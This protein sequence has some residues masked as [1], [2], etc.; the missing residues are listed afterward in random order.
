MRHLPFMSRSV[1]ASMLARTTRLVHPSGITFETPLL[2][3]SFSSKGF[4]HSREDGSS[5]LADI[6]RVA[7]EF[8]TDSMLVSAYDMNHELFPAINSP[9]THITIVDSGGYEVSDQHDL[10]SV[11]VQ[12]VEP[13]EWNKERHRKE[14]ERWPGHV[15][16]IFVTY[17][18]GVTRLPIRQQLEGAEDYLSFSDEHLITFLLRPET[19][20]QKYVQLDS[21]KKEVEGLGHFAMLGLTEKELGKS[22][23]ERM[24]MI[25]RIR[26]VLDEASARVP[27]HIFGCLDPISIPLYFMAGAEVFDGLAWLR[28]G[29]ADGVAMYRQNA[30][31]LRI[32]IDRTDDFVKM[33]TMQDNLGSLVDLRNRLRR[34]LLDRDFGKFGSHERLFRESLELLNTEEKG[35]A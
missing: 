4:G 2:V 23:L 12:K 22:Q 1:G 15:P 8:L 11:F 13:L 29:F 16:A 24:T 20:A 26:L 7:T 6:Y 30:A 9:I 3:P 14:L 18:D 17:D 10:S 33:K 32:G 25:A 5:E 31:A 19:K 27:I 21:I 35:V 34:F 28:Y